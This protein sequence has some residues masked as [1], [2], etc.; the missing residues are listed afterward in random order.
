MAAVT[1]AVTRTDDPAPDGCAPG[2]C[3]LREAI[4]AANAAAGPDTITLPAGIHTLA[5]LPDVTPDDGADGDLDVFSGGLEILG[6]GAD[7]TVIDGGGIDRIF[8][9]SN[10]ANTLRIADLTIRDGATSDAFGGGAIRNLAPLALE[11]VIVAANAASGGDGGAITNSGAAAAL[12]L[13]DSTLIGNSVSQ[14]GGGDGGALRNLNGGTMTLTNVTASGNF[15]NQSGGAMANSGTSSI[16]LTNVTITDNTATVDPMTPGSAGGGGIASSGGTVSLANTIL[17]GNHDGDP[18]PSDDPDCQGTL[19]SLGHNLVQGHDSMFCTF[20]PSTG[21]VVGMAPNLGALTDNGGP[22][23]THA[24]LAGS[25]AVD[26][27]PSG[28]PPTDQRGV[29]RPFGGACDIGAYE[30]A[31]C[32]AVAVNGIGTDGDDTL[33]GTDAADGVLGLAGNDEISTG[34][35]DDAVCAGDGNDT[36]RGEQGKDILRGGTGNDRLNGG[37]QRD[38]LFGE[39][40]KDRLNGGSGKDRCHGGPGK[41]RNRKCEKGKP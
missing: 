41:D 32:G 11:R 38:R 30:L 18:T 28:C 1:F 13:I 24:L 4:L 33:T 5:I 12:T 37:T 31:L 9:S 17:A 14:P 2:D 16:T 25:P 39:Q 3:S 7:T 8:D 10:P 23:M 29:P 26:H 36:L 20:V 21:D 40:G 27:I 22:T 19:T 15:A 34:A 6:A 35:G